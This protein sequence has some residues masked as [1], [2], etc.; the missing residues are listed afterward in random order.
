MEWLSSSLNVDQSTI[1]AYIGSL[2]GTDYHDWFEELRKLLGVDGKAL[3]RAFYTGMK[4]TIFDTDAFLAELKQ[5]LEP[6]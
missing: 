6:A 1:F 3:V 4:G 5:C 2:T